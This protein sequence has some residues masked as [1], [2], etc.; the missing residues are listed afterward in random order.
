LEVTH[1]NAFGDI[2]A[3]AEDG[4]FWRICPEDLYCRMI[5]K[6]QLEMES[7]WADGD[8]STDWEMRP[9]VELA[10]SKL[11]PLDSERCY[12][13][14]VPGPLGGEYSST[15]IEMGGIAEVVGFAG[16]IARQ[17]ENLPE[18]TPVRLKFIEP[19]Q[20]GGGYSS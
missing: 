11:G 18:G 6:T 14:S 16:V 9:L 7:L 2:I 13:L 8:F 3:R 20:L 10:A 17:I 1:I 12:C 19:D 15:N 4:R 5:A